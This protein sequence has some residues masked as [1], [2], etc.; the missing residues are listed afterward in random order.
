MSLND[1]AELIYFCSPGG[2]LLDV[3]LTLG[4]LLN[5]HF[6][7]GELLDVQLTWENYLNVLLPLLVPTDTPV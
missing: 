1:D 5:V 2:E 7:L 4:E 3:H 6:S